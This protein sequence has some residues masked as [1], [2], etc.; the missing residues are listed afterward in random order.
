MQTLLDS[1]ATIY[2]F[3]LASIM[4]SG[5]PSAVKYQIAQDINSTNASEINIFDMIEGYCADISCFWLFD[6][7]YR[8]NANAT[9]AVCSRCG[10]PGH[11]I[12]GCYASKHASGFALDP[13]TMTARA[14][15]LKKKRF[16]D[17]KYNRFSKKVLTSPRCLH[18]T[19]AS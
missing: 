19:V 7:P 1:K 14:K 12:D 16:D 13:S 18:Q 3:V 4:D 2:D 11:G 17:P 9:A 10:N 5:L 6:E 8:A 15:E